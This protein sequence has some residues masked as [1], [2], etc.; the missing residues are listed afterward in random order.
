[1]DTETVPSGTTV[2]QEGKGSQL[3]FHLMPNHPIFGFSFIVITKHLRDIIREGRVTTAANS[4]SISIRGLTAEG[5]PKGSV[6]FNGPKPEAVH[7]LNQ[8]MVKEEDVQEGGSMA[9]M[10][11]HAF[12]EGA[13]LPL[14]TKPAA[15]WT[16]LQGIPTFEKQDVTGK[17]RV[18]YVLTS[19][20][21]PEISFGVFGPWLDGFTEGLL[22]KAWWRDFNRKFPGAVVSRYGSTESAL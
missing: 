13:S 4:R 1:L 21:F 11:W 16:F 6:K 9:P 19:M 15:L 17:Y 12:T 14:G 5:M 8:H 2:V 10:E 22:I 7:F 3:S 20:A 18:V